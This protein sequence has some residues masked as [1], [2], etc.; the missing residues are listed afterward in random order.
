MQQGDV[1]V[2]QQISS[3]WTNFRSLP[4]LSQG[5]LQ[6]VLH[7]PVHFTTQDYV[8]RDVA[9]GVAIPLWW[10]EIELLLN[11]QTIWQIIVL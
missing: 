8:L 10:S 4:V 1:S 2:T 7:F 11:S 6:D 9:R 3:D 5:M